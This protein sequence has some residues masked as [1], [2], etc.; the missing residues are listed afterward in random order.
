MNGRQTV[1]WRVAFMLA[2][3]ATL[4]SCAPPTGTATIP[5]GPLNT[6]LDLHSG[7]AHASNTDGSSRGGSVLAAPALAPDIAYIL[8]LPAGDTVLPPAPGE[9]FT[10]A[11]RPEGTVVMRALAG[12]IETA[13]DSRRTFTVSQGE[14]WT[15]LPGTTEVIVEHVE[16]PLPLD[17]DLFV[18]PDGI[19]VPAIIP[20]VPAEAP[21][22]ITPT[23]P[24]EGRSIAY[25]ETVQS[26]LEEGKG[27][28][29][30]FEGGVGDVVTISMIGLGDLADTY[31][32]L[33]APDGTVLTEDDDSGDDYFAL[34]EEYELP[35]SGTYHIV[36]RAYSDQ[37]GSYVLTLYLGGQPT[38]VPCVD[39]D[40]SLEP[41]M[42]QAQERGYDL[43]CPT[44]PAFS[45]YGAFQEFR[46]NHFMIWDSSVREICVLI[47]YDDVEGTYTVYRDEWE[48]GMPEVHPDCA[49]MPPPAGYQLP[50]RGFGKVW[51]ESGLWDQIGWPEAHE[52]AAELLVQPTERGLLVRVGGLP[53]GQDFLFALDL[54]ER[55][56]IATTVP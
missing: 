16:E 53:G 5:S 39:L 25:G 50:I 37:A 43:G 49:H 7:V 40:H 26:A 17:L 22:F 13:P 46:A 14:Q 28:V 35:R 56:W 15:L 32:E 6:T 24:A 36:A 31:L 42:A 10:F 45:V 48:E 3:A 9:E 41:I 29:W 18:P 34:I 2:L 11:V 1:T 12:E 38:E 54:S 20:T 19:D 30:T 47:P 52:Q 33:Y 55:L 4:A 27:E 51:C 8:S 21:E 44:R 23:L